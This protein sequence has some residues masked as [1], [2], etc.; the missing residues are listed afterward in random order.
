MAFNPAAFI[1][2]CNNIEQNNPA[3]AF[4]FAK[5]WS[6]AFFAGYGNPTPPSLTNT[7]AQQAMLG[8]FILAYKDN[9]N[10]KKYMNAAVSTF[11]MAMAPGM[12]PLWAAIPPMSYQ[13]FA[14]VNIDT[15]KAKGQLGPALAAVTTPWFM[16]G[17]AIQT[18]SG[19][20]T[21]WL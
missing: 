19:V 20:S 17:T 16:S 4:D 2:N 9:N 15:V 6:D 5:A 12:L 13:G 14:Q 3:T 7:A 10:G 1:A 8:L 21:T 11:A 18:T